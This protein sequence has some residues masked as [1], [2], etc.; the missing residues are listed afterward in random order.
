MKNNKIILTAFFVLGLYF[1]SF[2]VLALQ[3]TLLSETNKY[4]S[5]LK[6][7]NSVNITGPDMTFDKDFVELGEV[8][9][10]E[11]RTLFY[12]LTNTG[13]EALEIELI[14]ACDCTKT[15]YPH[16]PIQ[17]GETIRIDV[18]FDSSDKDESEDIDI[19]IFFTNMDP[20]VDAPLIRTVKYHFDLVK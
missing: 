19:D 11:K 10:G 14:S 16:K 2:S 1:Q 8:K 5:I 3:N 7:W 6:T 15:T 12:D 13:D 17:P 4:P 9:K 18:I 20:E